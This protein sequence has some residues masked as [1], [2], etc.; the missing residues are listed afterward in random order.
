SRG[1][2]Q[3][4]DPRKDGL[5]KESG[6]RKS[7]RGVSA[8]GDVLLRGP[9]PAVLRR[10]FSHEDGVE[11]KCFD[12][13]FSEGAEGELKRPI[14]PEPPGGAVDRR[15]LQSFFWRVWAGDE[16][17]GQDPGLSGALTAPLP[18]P[19]AKGD[20]PFGRFFPNVSRPA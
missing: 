16:G 14:V 15:R 8:V 19:K 6:W 3:T 4:G 10:C 18:A 11:G 2:G 9:P 17:S 20:R 1:G 13:P 12:R 5:R 7:S